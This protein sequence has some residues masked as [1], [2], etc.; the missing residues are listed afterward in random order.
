MVAQQMG[1][2]GAMARE[3]APRHIPFLR[4]DLVT[5]NDPGMLGHYSCSDCMPAF[6]YAAD[7]RAI[8]A[9]GARSKIPLDN[10]IKKTTFA[11]VLPTSPSC[12][13]SF[14]ISIDICSPL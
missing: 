10:Q 13:T 4:Q 11:E 7:N 3:C 6:T 2:T 14:A 8:T 1:S 9:S 5:G 12:E